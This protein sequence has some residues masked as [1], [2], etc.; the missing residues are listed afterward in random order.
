MFNSY[1]RVIYLHCTKITDKKF[2]NSDMYIWL[3]SCQSKILLKLILV[4]SF[5]RRK[6][7][8][9]N[10]CKMKFVYLLADYRESFFIEKFHNRSINI[11]VFYITWSTYIL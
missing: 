10:V 1:T 4:I 6:D 8:I 7:W 11:L 2:K 5:Q 9:F 3:C